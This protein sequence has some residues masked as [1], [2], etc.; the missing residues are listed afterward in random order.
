MGEQRI[1]RGRRLVR[2]ASPQGRLYWLPEGQEQASVSDSIRLLAAEGWSRAEISRATGVRYQ[3]VRNVLEH[4]A[5]SLPEQTG[6]ASPVAAPEDG[7]APERGIAPAA[8]IAEVLRRARSEI[9]ALAGLPET[10][11]RLQ[12]HIED[13]QIDNEII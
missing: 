2:T 11:V 8:T 5:A 7:P 3:Y 10:A 4:D 13:Q 6:T 1:V 12:I 9:A